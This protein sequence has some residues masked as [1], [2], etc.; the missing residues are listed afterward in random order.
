MTSLITAM[1]GIFAV[2]NK[3]RHLLGCHTL[4]LWP[5]LALLITVGYI[6]YK[7]TLWDLKTILGQKW[8]YDFTSEE[9]FQLQS[10]VNKY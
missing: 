8:R 3:D 4:L 2:Y 10:S 5:C 6:S 7:D 1:I 9:Q